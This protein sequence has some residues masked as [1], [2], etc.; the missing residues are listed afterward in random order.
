MKNVVII[1]TLAYSIFNFRMN[2][3]DELITRGY[4][5]NIIAPKFDD[6][7]VKILKSKGVSFINVDVQA[8][9]VGILKL[10]R[11]FY[12][13]Y[14]AVKLLRP[15]YTISYS[16]K[17]NLVG[18][19]SSKLLGVKNIAMITGLGKLYVLKPKNWPQ[20]VTSKLLLGILGKL[21]G[22]SNLLIFQNEEDQLFFQDQRY[23]SKDSKS[24]VLNGSGVNTEYF[25]MQPINNYKTVLLIGRL[26][27]AKGIREF[28][29][30][31]GNIDKEDW[32][33]Q[34]LG[35]TEQGSD[36]ISPEEVGYLSSG[37][38]EYLGSA[39]DVR[40]YIYSSTF[41][42]LPAYREG[43]ARS[44]LEA[45][46]CGRP[47]L[48]SDAPGMRDLFDANYSLLFEPRNEVAIQDVLLEIRKLSENKVDRMGECARE[49]VMGKYDSA[50]VALSFVSELEKL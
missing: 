3:I 49:A 23:L 34:I 5:I 18:V 30:A 45:M 37:K 11:Y 35:W 4:R 27:Q 16:M 1:T 9:S 26:I 32:N 21:L 8:R 14:C 40:S 33:Y 38:V 50:T 46:A 10:L 29:R 22:R 17:A 2:L 15:D 7:Q 42:I 41:I 48:M 31:V 20:K 6:S 12:S 36:A 44:L 28:C 43:L 39:I 24:F 25:S 47:I 13:V 19:L